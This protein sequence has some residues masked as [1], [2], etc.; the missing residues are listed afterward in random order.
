MDKTGQLQD[1][2]YIYIYM[3]PSHSFIVIVR[4]DAN[5]EDDDNH[6]HDNKTPV[7]TIH[8]SCTFNVNLV[9]V[10]VPLFGINKINIK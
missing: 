2:I 1:N 6:A 3:S 9:V 5:I 7:N 8:T 10:I 4:F